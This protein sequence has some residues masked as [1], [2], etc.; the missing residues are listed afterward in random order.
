MNKQKLPL[1][2]IITPTFNI[3]ND[4]RENKFLQMVNSVHNQS[5]EN[6]E[7]IV[8][9]GKSSDGTVDLLKELA[10]KKWISYISEQDRGIY[11]AMNKGIRL[12]KGKYILFMNS[13]DFFLSQESVQD[14]VALL[15]STNCDYLFAN[16][17]MEDIGY[18]WIFG[19]NIS[20]FWNRMPFNHQT[21]FCKKNI[22]KKFGGFDLKY[23]FAADYDFILKCI[24]N[25]L[26][27]AYLNKT[28]SVFRVGGTTLQNKQQSQRE[29]AEILMKHCAKFYHFPSIDL[30]LHIVLTGVYI[31]DL[32]YNMKK[33][34]IQNHFKYFDANLLT[35]RSY[36]RKL[37]LFGFLPLLKIREEVI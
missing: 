34:M 29:Q 26:P 22:L 9:D 6:I 23:K 13:D 3:I 37:K 16:C 14:S 35:P 33:Y 11:D 28:I 36:E 19:N 25:D 21:M 18:E 32:I 8:I 30:A 12:A 24:F 7:H 17:L 4:N 15:E 2:S 31:K 10:S 1:I 5:Y 20:L 27:Y